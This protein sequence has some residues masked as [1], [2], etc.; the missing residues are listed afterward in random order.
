[1]TAIGSTSDDWSGGAGNALPNFGQTGSKIYGYDATEMNSPVLL[2]RPQFSIGGNTGDMDR[3]LLPSE[4]QPLWQVMTGFE[5]LDDRKAIIEIQKKLYTGGFYSSD[6]YKQQ[7][8]RKI[9]SFGNIDADTMNAYGDAVRETAR[10]GGAMTLDEVL[11]AHA[12]NNVLASQTAKAPRL[13]N[14]ESVKASAQQIAPKVVGKRL[15]DD[16]L[17][18]LA[19]RAESA[20]LS[21]Y[22]DSQ[23]Q[24]QYY[25]NSTNSEAFLE[26]QIRQL[27]PETVKAYQTFNN[28]SALSS[29]LNGSG[30]SPIAQLYRGSN[31]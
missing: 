30:Q 11:D 21:D 2:K 26:E 20:A 15:D 13:T 28:M 3:E 4:S 18:Q 24:S 10:R 6:Y 19:A 22:V 14:P 5:T 7:G 23:G 29:F 31:G 1:M 25:Q 16:T 17:N 27:M 8:G 9:P 12:A